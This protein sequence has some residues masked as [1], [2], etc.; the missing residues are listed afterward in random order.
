MFKEMRDAIQIDKGTDILDHIHSLPEEEQKEAFRKIQV[1]ESSAMTKQTP[2]AGL[3]TL[4]EYLD[5]KGIKK[6]ICTRNFESVISFHIPNV[7]ILMND[8]VHP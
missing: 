3:I 6:A 1:I 5:R 2:Q 4:M 7:F 8:A